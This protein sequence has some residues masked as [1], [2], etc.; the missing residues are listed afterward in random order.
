MKVPNR[1]EWVQFME[2]KTKHIVKKVRL[3]AP[4]VNEE[5]GD[6]KLGCQT[7]LHLT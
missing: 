4:T 2:K 6:E 5:N 1:Q 7:A 3:V